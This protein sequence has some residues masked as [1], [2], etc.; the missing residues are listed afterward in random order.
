MGAGG[1]GSIQVKP[2]GSFHGKNLLSPNGV[3]L[4]P[5][6]S[7]PTIRRDGLPNRNLCDLW[8]LL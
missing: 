5:D 2:F 3:R 6:W 7:R 8:E 1:K 4:T